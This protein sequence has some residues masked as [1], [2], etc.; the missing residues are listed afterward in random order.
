MNFKRLHRYCSG[1]SDEFYFDV[2]ES[3]Q[4]DLTK[5]TYINWHGKINPTADWL[6]MQ[7]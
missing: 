7:D 1:Q 2:L 4:N 5:P 3:K 6:K